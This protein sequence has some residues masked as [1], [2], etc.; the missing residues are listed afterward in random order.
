MTLLI[1]KGKIKN[2]KIKLF[3][4][5]SCKV[6]SKI[7][8]NNSKMLNKLMEMQ[9]IFGIIQENKIL[10]KIKKKINS[11]NDKFKENN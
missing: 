5:N 3:N 6:I 1:Q 4:N 2:L 9:M 8:F 11:H 10:K 7:L